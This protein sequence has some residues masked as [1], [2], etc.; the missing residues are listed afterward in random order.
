MIPETSSQESN[1][2]EQSNRKNKP[3]LNW[4]FLNLWKGFNNEVFA[5]AGSQTQLQE[6]STSILLLK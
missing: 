6:L 4:S 1:N 5:I 2:V 3:I